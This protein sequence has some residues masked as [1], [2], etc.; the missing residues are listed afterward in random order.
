MPAAA[1]LETSL[2]SLFSHDRPFGP[3]NAGRIDD[4]AAFRQLFDTDSRVYADLV[5]HPSVSLIVGR[6]GAGKTA[7]LRSVTLLNQK[8]LIVELPAADAF[9]QL[10][11]TVQGFPVGVSPGERLSKV[12]NLLFWAALLAKIRDSAPSEPSL[13]A[14]G[15]FL[16]GLEMPRN[17]DP[18]FAMRQLAGCLR[19]R[20]SEHHDDDAVEAAADFINLLQFGG[21]GF[22]EAQRSATEY[23]NE[24][25]TSAIILMDSLD[26]FKLETQENRESLKGLLRCQAE[27]HSTGSPYMLRCCLPAELK[28]SVYL[29]LS[30]NPNKD[31]ESK[32]LVHWSA[33]ELLRIGAS[34]FLH[35]LRLYYPEAY[36]QEFRL[37][38]LTTRTGVRE[39]WRR[40]MPHQVK[41]YL[42]LLEDP[43]AMV[44][45][46]TQ[47]LPRQFLMYMNSIAVRNRVI[48]G[49]G[50]FVKFEPEAVVSGIQDVENTLCQEIFSAYRST[51]PGAEAACT[52]CLPQL[53]FRFRNGDLHSVYNR[54]GKTADFI[55]DYEDLRRTLIGIGALGRVVKETGTYIEG[56]FNYSFDE[57]LNLRGDDP[58]CIHALFSRVFNQSAGATASP[59]KVV[60]AHDAK[61]PT[62]YAT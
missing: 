37:Y 52:R 20:A 56:E 16:D 59:K 50:K 6:R 51:Y 61:L 54:H 23:L 14:V 7:L 10:V 35:Y 19:E 41:S 18:Y 11:R 29:Q 5:R 36:S 9:Q 17:V 26:D 3:I 39:F 33:E 55:S 28:N 30:D 47:L 49:D 42:G 24:S 12:W 58:L 4:P 43:V 34:R 46:H 25:G 60:Y 62:Q 27:F 1:Q 32:L 2:R 48:T 15:R 57:E 31:F 44:L 38:K 21:V 13:V 22:R 8:Q 53:P 40:L 45:R